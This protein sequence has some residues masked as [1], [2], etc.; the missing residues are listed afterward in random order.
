MY[1]CDNCRYIFREFD[2]SLQYSQEQK[3]HVCTLCGKSY[4]KW[5][6]GKVSRAF[7]DVV[8]FAR[9][10]EQCPPHSS[11]EKMGEPLSLL[12]QALAESKHFVHF[13]T[14]SIDT[15]LLGALSIVASK[16]VTVRGIVGNNRNHEFVTSTADAL[17][18]SLNGWDMRFVVGIEGHNVRSV[19]P[20][21]TK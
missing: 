16:G 15:T 11:V 9:I 4:D 10:A 14:F 12:Y 8:K 3:G 6:P 20:P 19:S 21:H 17:M 5:L 13:L 2:K 7:E 18:N 1:V